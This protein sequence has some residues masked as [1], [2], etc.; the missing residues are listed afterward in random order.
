M[1]ATLTA[2]T[3]AT[4]SLDG[5]VALPSEVLAALSL[6]PGDQV[7]FQIDDDGRVFVHSSAS[8]ARTLFD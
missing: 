3:S 2:Q 8:L 1:D 7:Y 5:T 6:A 4:L